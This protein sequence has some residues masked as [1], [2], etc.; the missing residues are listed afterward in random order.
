VKALPQT[1]H[2]ARRHLRVQAI[3]PDSRRTRAIRLLAMILAHQVKRGDA[4][5]R[6]TRRTQHPRQ[7]D[8]EVG[9]VRSDYR[10][11][12][13]AKVG[14]LR[15]AREEPVL[16]PVKAG[17]VQRID[18]PCVNRT[19]AQRRANPVDRLGNHENQE[20]MREEIDRERGDSRRAA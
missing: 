7:R 9:N 20:M 10:S 12:H 18:A 19:V 5:H 13:E 16:N 6:E 4:G 2:D 11:A 17:R 15:D 3:E 8:I 1:G 14:Q